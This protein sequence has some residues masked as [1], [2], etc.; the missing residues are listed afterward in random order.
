MKSILS[1]AER[2]EVMTYVSDELLNETHLQYST[3]SICDTKNAEVE[4]N[5]INIGIAEHEVRQGEEVGVENEA[6][7]I[8]DSIVNVEG[9]DFAIKKER[10]KQVNAEERL[11]LER[12]R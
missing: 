9:I 12:L 8:D 3:T 1:K 5:E 11:V 6:A 2:E 4:D 7:C 10:T